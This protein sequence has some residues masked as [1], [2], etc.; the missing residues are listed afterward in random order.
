M[1]RLFSVTVYLF[2]AVFL[3]SNPIPFSAYGGTNAMTASNENKS[4]AINP[5][6]VKSLVSIPDTA[7]L[8]FAAPWAGTRSEFG[9][10]SNE[11]YVAD[12]EGKNAT[13]ITHNRYLYNHFA[14]S[15]DRK[16][17]AAIRYSNGDTNN[18]RRIDFRDKKTLWIIDLADKKEWAL[19][20]EEDAGWGG[21]DWS[22][23]GQYVYA[24][25]FKDLKSNIYRIRT[26]GTGLENITRGI[27]KILLPD[28]PNKWVSDT[29]VSH[30]GEWITFLYSGQ[31]AGRPG[32]RSPS[33]SRIAVCRIDGS[34]PRFLTDG[35][36][37]EPLAHG[38]WGPG[39]FDPEFSPDGKHVC[40]QRATDAGVNFATRLPSHDIMRVNIAGTGLKRL[41]PEGNTGVHGIS[42][43]SWDN[44]VTFSEWNQSDMFVGLVV[45]NADGSGYRRL[46]SLPTGASHVRWISPIGK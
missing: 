32:E 8:V 16:M 43:W 10:P 6:D 13:Q 31:Q 39:D 21:V 42:D 23:D 19:V 22:P 34:E 40:F 26:D 17:I 38:L 5:I 24:S 12:A 30:D 18:D 1:K 14:V 20:P 37:I 46:T 11:L 45:V 28:L 9:F 44:R 3:V 2:I 41:S 33:T 27:E 4:S 36:G 35:G 15:P 29:G 7:D 25:I